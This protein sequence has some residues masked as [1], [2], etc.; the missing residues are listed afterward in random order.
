VVLQVGLVGVESRYR[1]DRRITGEREYQ[2]NSE[3]FDMEEL[4][5]GMRSSFKAAM[6]R[7]RVEDGVGIAQGVAIQVERVLYYRSGPPGPDTGGRRPWLF[8][9]GSR[10]EMF[11]L[12]LDPAPERR[13]LSV[14]ARRGPLTDGEASV[15][16]HGALATLLEE[17]GRQLR[18]NVQ[19]GSD[20]Y[21]LDLEI[22][23]DL[24]P[25]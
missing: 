14:R 13:L 19:P 22:L 11:S 9:F 3:V 5:R 23:V 6:F 20:A 25:R 2:L 8:I 15:L 24:T 4:R 12:F 17:S 21:R 16:R 1:D 10:N 7:G 18:A